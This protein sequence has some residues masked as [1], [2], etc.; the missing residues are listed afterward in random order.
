MYDHQLHQERLIRTYAPLD[1]GSPSV[2]TAGYVRGRPLDRRDVF[3]LRVCALVHDLAEIEHGDHVT[4]AKHLAKHTV[5]DEIRSTRAFVRRALLESDP[6]R[7]RRFERTTMRAY[8]VDY[9]KNH[10]LHPLFKLYEKYSY[11]EGAVSAYERGQ[12]VVANAV[13]LVHNVF[14][15]QIVALVAAA[16]AGVPSAGAILRE[17]ASVIDE[18]FRWVAGSGHRD[19]DENEAAFV[20]AKHAWAD[21]RNGLPG[22]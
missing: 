15:N 20:R 17:R 18:M 12:E 21:F 7:A 16:R 5:A 10:R 22:A 8:S 3:V 4:D 6:R 1:E 9:E 11:L 19:T 14:K 2:V 13:W